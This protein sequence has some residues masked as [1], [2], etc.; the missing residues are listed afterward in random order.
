[1]NKSTSHNEH[2]VKSRTTTARYAIAALLAMVGAGILW[3]VGM[4][5][6]AIGTGMAS[7]V[8]LMAAPLLG[9]EI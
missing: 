5:A 3:D 8:L 9:G 2:H 6:T 1:V 7:M 4:P